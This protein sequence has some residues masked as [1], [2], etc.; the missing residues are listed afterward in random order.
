MQSE[1]EGQTLC[2]L[3]RSRPDRCFVILSRPDRRFVIL[4][5]GAVP[6]Y[7]HIGA[8][9]VKL[10]RVSNRGPADYS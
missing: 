2:E 6:G 9:G 1:T 5:R 3:I 10:G 8:V 4:S 7:C